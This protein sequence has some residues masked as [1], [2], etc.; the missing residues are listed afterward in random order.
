MKVLYTCIYIYSHC[1]LIYIYI[2]IDAAP[3]ILIHLEAIASYGGRYAQE[4][5]RVL[6]AH[7]VVSLSSTKKK[8]LS[9]PYLDN[10]LLYIDF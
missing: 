6:L 7:T 9:I 2:Y 3:C 4:Y 5:L 1:N 8:I 10:Y